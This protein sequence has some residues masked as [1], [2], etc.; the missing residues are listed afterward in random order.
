MH[1]HMNIKNK[2]GCVCVLVCVD[3]IYSKF[4]NY[5]PIVEIKRTSI[6]VGT[7]SMTSLNRHDILGGGRV[8]FSFFRGFFYLVA[9]FELS[10][11]EI[12]LEN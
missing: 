3:R 4:A 11:S 9:A 7:V 5:R 2:Y 1:G 8:S 10:R 12:F 6:H